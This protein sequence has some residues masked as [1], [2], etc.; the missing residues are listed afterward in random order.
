MKLGISES[1]PQERQTERIK[2]EEKDKKQASLLV[3]LKYLR[4]AHLKFYTAVRHL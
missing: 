4:K 3:P 2:E 1:E